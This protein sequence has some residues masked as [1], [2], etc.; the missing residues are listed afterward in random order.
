[1]EDWTRVVLYGTYDGFTRSTVEPLQIAV[2]LD[3]GERVEIPSEC[4]ISEDQIVKKDE[5]KL[6]DVIKRIKDLDIGAQEVWFNEIL[7][8]LGSDYGSAKYKDGYYK[9]KLDG[10]WVGLQLK[11]ADEIRQELNK[12]VVK[13]FVADWYEENK[14]SFDYN[15]WEYLTDWEKQEP[16]DFKNWINDENNIFQTL[17]NMHQFGYKV[18]KEKRYL[19]KMKGLSENDCYLRLGR[20]TNLWWFGMK[21][22]D[23]SAEHTRKDLEQAGFGWVFDCPG[24][25]IEE[26][27]E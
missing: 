16:S 10:E 15:L 7:N 26:V 24:V 6:R 3:G 9:G 20:N 11:D 17:V 12:P 18:E 2:R 5:I 23:G 14:D 8:E 1:M 19:V 22:N 13:Q 21:Y 4:V 25:E 27:E